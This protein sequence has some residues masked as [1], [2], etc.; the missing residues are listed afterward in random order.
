MKPVEAIDGKMASELL[1]NGVSHDGSAPSCVKPNKSCSGR[2]SAAVT[3]DISSGVSTSSNSVV[4]V[5]TVSCP[6]SLATPAE[7]VLPRST[8]SNKSAKVKYIL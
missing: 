6:T 4:G 5:T 3:D 8:I 7:M 2:A 1:P